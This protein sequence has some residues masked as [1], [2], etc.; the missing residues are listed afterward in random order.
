VTNHNSV[1]TQTSSARH[2]MGR[3][4][5]RTILLPVLFLTSIL[6][7]RELGPDNRGTYALL[8]LATALVAPLATLGLQ[9][10]IRYHI[11]S[12]QYR[13]Q[14]LGL[15]SPLFGLLHGVVTALVLAGLYYAG[16]LAT[17]FPTLHDVPCSLPLTIFAVLPLQTLQ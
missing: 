6:V 17:F 10:R 11:S 13:P 7:A 8:L 16:V 4:L 2:T 15:T 12:R 5:T 1:Q 14:E 3:A 9:K